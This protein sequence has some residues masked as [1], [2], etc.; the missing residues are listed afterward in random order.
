MVGG[1][2]EWWRCAEREP[3]LWEE[4]EAAAAE[5]EGLLWTLGNEVAVSKSVGSDA[6]S[7]SARSIAA[8]RSLLTAAACRLGRAR[9]PVVGSGFAAAWEVGS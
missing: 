6:V 9:A 7:S 8:W 1:E 4:A 3:G 5:V 2:G